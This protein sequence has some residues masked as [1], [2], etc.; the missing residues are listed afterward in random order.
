VDRF[1]SLPDERKSGV[2]W[3]LLVFIG[4][5]ALVPTL[6]IVGLDYLQVA[7]LGLARYALVGSIALPL[8]TAFSLKRMKSK[9]LRWG[10][11]VIVTSFLIWN[12]NHWLRP[13]W[14]PM[15]DLRNE[16]WADAVATIVHGDPG[17]PV[18]LA[19]NV[20][21]DVD[22]RRDRSPQFQEYLKFPV[23]G[24]DP[25]LENPIVPLNSQGELFTDQEADAVEAGGGG[26]LIVRDKPKNVPLIMEL[27]ERNPRSSDWQFDLAAFPAPMPNY[28]L[29]FRIT[30]N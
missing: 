19:G 30:R 9:V 22:A 6:T 16:N 3:T 20:L 15:S 11:L 14:P 27:I 23:L 28:V 4:L 18:L 26:W 1:V 8:F 21:E 12:S 17:Y 13:T 7:P 25:N 10:A 5:W 2:S 29:L 24:A